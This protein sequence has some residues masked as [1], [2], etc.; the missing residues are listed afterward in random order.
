MRVLAPAR[1]EFSAE[2][3]LTLC[4]DAIDLSFTLCDLEAKKRQIR[5]QLKA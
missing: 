5:G 4:I 2:D 1:P 3:G